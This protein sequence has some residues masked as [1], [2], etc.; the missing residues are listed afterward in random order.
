MRIINRCTLHRDGAHTEVTLAARRAALSHRLTYHVYQRKN[1]VLTFHR[2]Y[3]RAEVIGWPGERCP[4][5]YACPDPGTAA[6]DDYHLT[7]NA[8]LVDGYGDPQLPRPTGRQ[9]LVGP[10]PV[11]LGA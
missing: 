2:S 5:R 9:A 4:G 10:E 11:R 1:G 3:V 8:L 7:V 6:L